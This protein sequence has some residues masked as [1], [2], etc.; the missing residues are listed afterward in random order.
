MRL[1]K[2]VKCQKTRI[3][4]RY[5]LYKLQHKVM[6]LMRLLYFKGKEVGFKNTL[7]KHWVGGMGKRF[8]EGNT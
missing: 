7:T 5:K 1:G 2:E 6:C 4:L 3:H 8:P